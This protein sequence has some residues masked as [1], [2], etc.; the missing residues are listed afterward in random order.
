[1]KKWLLIP[2]LIL[3]VLLILM[4]TVIPSDITVSGYKII[5]APV[6][7][8]NRIFASDGSIKKWWP[9]E[10]VNDTSFTYQNVQYHIPLTTPI[11]FSVTT[12]LSGFF[13]SG[14]TSTLLV[15][16]DTSAIQLQYHSFHTSLNPFK[17]V[18]AYFKTLTLK[19]QLDNI[20]KSFAQF[21]E[22]K[23]NI[24]GLDIV[25]ARVKDSSLIST[26]KTF[27]QYPANKDISDLISKLK[28]HITEN[29]G[30]EKDYPMLKIRINEE[31]RYEAMVAIPLLKDIPV[32]DDI[33]IKKMV[34]GN[35]LE[36]KVVGGPSAISTG[37]ASL[38][39]Y[40]LDYNKTSPATPFQL[41]ITDRYKE[42][43]TSKWVTILKYP[44]F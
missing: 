18:D 34:L 42:T 12:S 30:I 26:K 27:S 38:K 28:Q 22:K 36:A 25:N 40:V 29:G 10:I 7:T 21:A 15:K 39:N 23:S 44:V 41:L 3:S 14:E 2:V 4:F 11:G 5:H 6:G 17:R 19:K 24:Y 35:I 1:M 20:L 32:K 31:N 37:E 13:L 9:G 43:D 16:R 33:I 8:I